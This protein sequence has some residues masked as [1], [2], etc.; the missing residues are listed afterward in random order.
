M[1]LFEINLDVDAEWSCEVELVLLVA[2][3]GLLDHFRTA[4]VIHPNMCV[5]N[6]ECI[7][8]YNYI[9]IYIMLFID[10]YI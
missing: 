4:S 2:Q 10:T 7:Y 9:Y 8:I 3:C 1:T 5:A 6:Q